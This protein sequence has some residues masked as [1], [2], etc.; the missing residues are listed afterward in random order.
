MVARNPRQSERASSLRFRL[1][2]AG[3]VS[4]AAL[5][6]GAGL[7][8]AEPVAFYGL[9]DLPGGDFESVM[10]GMS[11]DGRTIV[12]SSKVPGLVVS[13][14]QA[15]R[16]SLD[17]GIQPLPYRTDSPS[18]TSR[19]VDVSDDSLEIL[20]YN[21]PRFAVKWAAGADR[22]IDYPMPPGQ[23]ASPVAMSGDGRVAVGRLG[24]S[25]NFRP[26]RWNED[27]QPLVM[28]GSSNAFVRGLS[29]DGSFAVG[30]DQFGTVSD[31]HAVVWDAQ[32]RMSRLPEADPS[33]SSQAFNVSSDDAFIVGTYSLPGGSGFNRA[34]VWSL[35]GS[36]PELLSGPAAN[37]ST[38][39]WAAS[40]GA[41][42]VLGR[43]TSLQG[44]SVVFWDGNRQY[45]ELHSFLTARGID[46]T[47]W[48]LTD[49][50]GIS[51][52]GRVIA[53]NG[54][55]PD[56]HNEAWVAYIPTPGTALVLAAVPA[57]A[58]RRRRTA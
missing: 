3:L 33:R 18:G 47:G 19:A 37:S 48:R 43:D 22:P 14:T 24:P 46:L 17:T 15:F 55:N 38:W 4:A 40:N 9:G 2:A 35:D 28:E 6:L 44:S 57:I 12:G 10:R 56:G 27:E 39:A 21:D 26:V 29:R 1:R 50:V 34:A 31:T 51:A 32:G 42:I 52:D 58:A 5:G 41:T 54:R 45:H 7:A 25:L 13:R 53:G 11:R 16:W 20:G 23:F 49:A 8:A 36:L 30:S